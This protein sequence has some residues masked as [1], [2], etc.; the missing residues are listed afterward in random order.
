MNVGILSMQQVYNYGSFLQAFSLKK[1]FE[2]RGHTVTFIDIIP[3]RIIVENDAEKL[4]YLSK[5]DRHL[6]KRIEHYVKAKEM[7][8]IHFDDYLKYLIQS[9]NQIP[10]EFD[11]VVIGS[12]E[13]FNFSSPSKWGFT[14]QLFGDIKNAKKI[15]T[16]A[17]SCGSSSYRKAEE[18]KVVNE[19]KECLS[20]ISAFSVR[21]E[22]TQD[23]VYR[24]TGI[25]AC[26][27]VDP[28][29]LYDYEDYIPKKMTKKPYVL[30]YAYSNRI[31]SNN[32]IAAIK[33]FAQDNGLDILCVGMFQNWCSNN[34]NANAF[35]LLSYVKN[36]R[37][38]I[39]DTFHGTVFSIKYNVPFCSIIR[40]SN[41]N[42]LGGLLRQFH[43][44]NRRVDDMGEMSAII[45]KQINWNFVNQMINTERNKSKEYFNAVCEGLL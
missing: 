41:Q 14:R 1:Q 39:T 10:E 23:F 9:Q 8:K 15:V 29:F 18:L 13:V 7:D 40:E 3:G 6:F 21:D 32:E 22:N 27:N 16:Y 4:H 37:F 2:M 5:F 26:I 17:A 43:L 28:V 33:Q 31:S 25:K 44:E 35:E 42:K 24:L 12:D 11:I 34:I 38:I 36:A 19:L 45:N 20:H 30:I